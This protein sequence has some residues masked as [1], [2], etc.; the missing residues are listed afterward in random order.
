MVHRVFNV[1]KNIITRLNFSPFLFTLVV[2]VWITANLIGKNR[3]AFAKYEIFKVLGFLGFSLFI[4]YAI[5]LLVFHKFKKERLSYI[6]ASLFLVM[7]LWNI[8][9]LNSGDFVRLD[10]FVQIPI[11]IGV[12]LLWFFILSQGKRW[13]FTTVSLFLTVFIVEQARRIIVDKYL[14]LPEKDLPSTYIYQDFV[15]KPNIYLL[16]FDA[17]IP[18]KIARHFLKLKDEKI[19]YVETLKNLNADIIPN[20]FANFSPTL[21]SLNSM[22]ALDLDWWE[23]KMYRKN[24]TSLTTGGQWSPTYDIFQ[25]NGYN[26]QLIYQTDFF[27]RDKRRQKINYHHNRAKSRG[28]CTRPHSE[29]SFYGY[30]SLDKI[31]RKPHTII[32][33]NPYDRGLLEASEAKDPYFTLSYFFSPGHTSGKYNPHDEDSFLR[34]K[35]EFL[36]R[37]MD[38]AA[39]EIERQVA[40]IRENDKEGII[41]VFGDHGALFAN[42]L[43][44]TNP[45]ADSPYN[46]VEIIQDRHAILTAVL[47]PHSCKIAEEGVTTLNDIMVNIIE[48][49]TDNKPVLQERIN[50]N[51]RYV[52][53]LYE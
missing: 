27:S 47:D 20:T 15:K 9:L 30:C 6:L 42:G 53:A 38:K 35:K 48:C 25:K 29:Y 4:Q 50:N 10:I 37:R 34:Y 21:K 17:L 1:I 33:F 3:G 32:K 31:I 23:E 36:G 2:S 8:Y 7:N 39:M 45:G 18:E 14:F 22:L 12:F 11:L 28:F 52:D 40:L 46:T 19:S 41:V 24:K 16:S 13:V 26:I 5:L 51:K 44:E 49:L 43:N